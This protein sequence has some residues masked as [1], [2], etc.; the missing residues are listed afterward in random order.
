MAIFGRSKF[1]F[2]VQS[3]SVPDNFKAGKT[4][5]AFF[6]L[7]LILWFAGRERKRFTGPNG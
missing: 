3:L 5:V 7:L 2:Q 4:V 6:V 1:K